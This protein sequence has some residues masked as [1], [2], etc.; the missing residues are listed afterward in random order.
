MLVLLSPPP[1]V[2]RVNP[3]RGHCAGIA[4]QIVKYYFD[5]SSNLVCSRISDAQRISALCK[6][7][8][9]SVLFG[10]F[11]MASFYYRWKINKPFN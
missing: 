11:F 4:Q 8:G 3:D 7:R 10:D 2:A 9:C 6:P 5:F 1:V